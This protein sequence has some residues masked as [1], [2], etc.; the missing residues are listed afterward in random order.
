MTVFDERPVGLG[1]AKPIFT[2]GPANCQ[3]GNR[4]RPS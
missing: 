4:R 2:V 3:A 1:Q